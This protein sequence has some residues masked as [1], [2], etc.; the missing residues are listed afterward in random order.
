VFDRIFKLHDSK[1][2]PSP[3]KHPGAPHTSAD[4]TWPP[5]RPLKHTFSFYDFD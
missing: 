3:Q 1:K 5:S 2:P 4:S